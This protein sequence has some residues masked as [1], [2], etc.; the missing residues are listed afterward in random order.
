M[1]QVYWN[2]FDQA[3][4]GPCVKVIVMNTCETIEAGREIG[5]EYPAPKA[6]TALI[7]TGS[8]FTIISR[9]FANNWKLVQ[10]GARSPIRTMGG[11]CLCDEYSGSISFPDSNL[12]EIGIVR[13]RAVDFNREPFYSCLIGRDILKNWDIRFDGRSKRV[14]IAG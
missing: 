6:I 13:L 9:T 7:D 11:D 3:D 8:P 10:T 2:P 5:F 4:P 1:F 14:T 12:P